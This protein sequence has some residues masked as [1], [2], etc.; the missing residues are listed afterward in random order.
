MT[1]GT[2]NN[3]AFVFTTPARPADPRPGTRPARELDRYERIRRER[4]GFLPAGPPRAEHG[5]TDPREPIAVLADVLDRDGAAL[6]ASATRRRNL[7]NAD[8]LGILQ[9]IWTAETAGARHDRYRDLVRPRSRPATGRICPPGPVAVP[10]HAGGR[11]GRPG[12]G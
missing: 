4:Q 1:R 5:R 6:S 9:A 7:A 8:H 2:D 12:P 10:H 3:M 11:T